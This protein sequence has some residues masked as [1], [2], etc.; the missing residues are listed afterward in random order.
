MNQNS[1]H[2]FTN[3]RSLSLPKWP[4]KQ[5]IFSLFAAGHPVRSL[6]RLIGSMFCVSVLATLAACGSSSS[7]GSNDSPKISD[8]DYE[9]DSYKGLPS[10]TKKHEGVTAYV[11]DQEQGYV[12]ENGKW[13][14]D[15]AA[16]EIRSSSSKEAENISSCVDKTEMGE[17]SSS[18]AENLLSSSSKENS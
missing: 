8:A 2:S 14:E 16:V 11:I 6:W 1:T 7:T 9:V 5:F 3:L 17:V 18:S 10:C 13:V 15:D 4:T 12:C